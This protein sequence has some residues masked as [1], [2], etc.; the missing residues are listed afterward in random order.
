M[1]GNKKSIQVATNV[2]ITVMFFA[3]GCFIPKNVKTIIRNPENN[4]LKTTNP[5]N[6][7][8]KTYPLGSPFVLPSKNKNVTNADIT[9][10]NIS[11]IK[12]AANELNPIFLIPLKTS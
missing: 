1:I 7:A 10:K 11:Q 2:K 12:V 4:D 8:I 5:N 9:Q 6:A 3:H